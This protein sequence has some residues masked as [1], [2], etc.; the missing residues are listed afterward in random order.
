MMVAN[1]MADT[2]L[3]I[4]IITGSNYS[5]PANHHCRLTGLGNYYSNTTSRKL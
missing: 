1:F 4:I 3:T 5:D 2:N